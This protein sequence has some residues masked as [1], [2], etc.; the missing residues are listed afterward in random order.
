M[1]YT[2]IFYT[3]KLLMLFLGS[4]MSDAWELIMHFV[5]KQDVNYDVTWSMESDAWHLLMHFVFKQIVNYDVTGSMTSDAWQL[6]MHFV[7]KQIV[8]YDVTGS[9]APDEDEQGAGWGDGCPVQGGGEES[10]AEE[11]ARVEQGEK[12]QEEIDGSGFLFRQ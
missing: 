7:F 5:F 12:R 11:G 2:E 8:S 6:L 10:V 1:K 9:G 3:F 4:I